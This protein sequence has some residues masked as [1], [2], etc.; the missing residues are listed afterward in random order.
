MNLQ[1]KFRT[2]RI[3]DITLQANNAIPSRPFFREYVDCINLPLFQQQQR[4]NRSENTMVL[5]LMGFL[6]SDRP[7]SLR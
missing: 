2:D 6:A 4:K 1:F 5:F 7:L 3:A